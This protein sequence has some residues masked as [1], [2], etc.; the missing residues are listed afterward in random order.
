MLSR[1]VGRD[2]RR[3]TFVVIASIAARLIN[4]LIL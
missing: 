1:V 2:G 3:T 4:L